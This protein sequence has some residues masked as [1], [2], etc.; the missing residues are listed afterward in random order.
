MN[1]LLFQVRIN[2][3]KKKSFRENCFLHVTKHEPDNLMTQCTSKDINY[4]ERELNFTRKKLHECLKV[5]CGW[6][7]SSQNQASLQE[8]L[9][10]SR[11]RSGKK[12]VPVW[13]WICILWCE[14][15]EGEARA[16]GTKRPSFRGRS[17]S[18]EGEARE[19][20]GGGVWGGA[21][22]APPQKIFKNS[23]MKWCNL[24][25]CCTRYQHNLLA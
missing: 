11:A 24:V 9:T 6:E 15:I 17:P 2:S 12:E 20:A 16:E 1:G 22:W 25:H 23:N 13:Y 7:A 4:T 5:S 21:R 18:I 19:K 14:D 3:W 10:E 8:R